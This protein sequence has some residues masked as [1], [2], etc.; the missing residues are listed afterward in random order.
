M[1]SSSSIATF[2]Y[3]SAFT[4]SN[5]IIP[6]LDQHPG[7]GS[8]P[9]QSRCKYRAHT[10]STTASRSLDHNHRQYRRRRRK[11]RSLLVSNLIDRFCAHPSPIETTHSTPIC[12]PTRLGSPICCPPCRD[13]HTYITS[14]PHIPPRDTDPSRPTESSLSRKRNGS[15]PKQSWPTRPAFRMA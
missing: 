12:L 14:L 10:P 11:R 2:P 5:D 13:L 6:A 4:I 9:S 15:S 3:R 7:A 8:T 1:A